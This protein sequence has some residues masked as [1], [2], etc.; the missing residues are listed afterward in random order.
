MK[1]YSISIRQAMAKLGQDLK[2]ARLRR[3]L[4]M[5]VI[6]ERANIS[7]ETLARIQ[8]GDPGVSIGNYAAVVWA[9][10]MKTTWLD[11]ADIN[12]D[13]VGQRIDADNLPKRVR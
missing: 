1:K 2:E 10:G 13:H 12:N 5:S 8:R 3:K 9:L 11:F 4:K 7:K 6:A